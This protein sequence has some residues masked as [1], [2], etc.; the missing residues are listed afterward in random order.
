MNALTIV[1]LLAVVLLGVTTMV[2]LSIK[3][4]HKDQ[5][6]SDNAKGKST[7]NNYRY[8]IKMSMMS[9]A[10]EGVFRKLVELCEGQCYVVPQVHLSSL[11]E[12]KIPG[13]KYSAAFSHINGKSV[14]FV[15]LDQESLKPL[16]AIELDDSSHNATDRQERDQEVERI[17]AVAKFPLVRLTQAMASSREK[18]GEAIMS[19][20]NAPAKK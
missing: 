17:F 8:Q 20:V 19:A 2:L 13:Q 1:L 3:V 4:A 15:L 10:E 5:L 16:C 9:R 11:F 12:H 18:V 6:P 7:T 14:D